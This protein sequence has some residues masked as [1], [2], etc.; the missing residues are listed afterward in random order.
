MAILLFII[1]LIIGLWLINHYM[2]QDNGVFMSPCLVTL[3]TVFSICPQLFSLFVSNYVDHSILPLYILTIIISILAFHCG[4]TFGMNRI[5]SI[6]CENSIIKDL[7]TSSNK[8]VISICTLCGI[9]ALLVYKGLYA[10]LDFVVGGFFQSMGVLALLLSIVA[11]RDLN[12]KDAKIYLI[13]LL[14]N[15]W[16]VYD[17]AVNVKGSRTRIFYMLVWAGMFLSSVYPLKKKI[18]CKTFVVVFIIGSIMS[19]SIG[20]YRTQIYSGKNVNA[21]SVDNVIRNYKNLLSGT[22]RLGANGNDLYNGAR[23][24]NHCWENFDYNYGTSI[25]NGA[26]FYYVPSRFLG[27]DTKESLMIKLENRDYIKKLTNSVTTTTGFADAFAI[28]NIAGCF[29]FFI[30]GAFQGKWW[31]LSKHSQFYFVL[32]SYS[33]MYIA[34][35]ISHGIVYYTSPMLM[36]VI[37]LYPLIKKSIIWK[38]VSIE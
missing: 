34:P 13:S 8:L 16:C 23:Y 12:W 7:D 33:I 17:Y 27:K 14:I 5:D 24:V 10:G 15:F 22:N 18:I 21:F 9:F 30:V 31:R 3:M 35:M 26:V 4:F 11:I 19:F 29:F 37:L 32:Y 25:W 38:K 28:F 1:L 36:W 20:D 6:I 2:R